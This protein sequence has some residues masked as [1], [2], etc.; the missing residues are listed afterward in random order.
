MDRNFDS[1]ISR[2]H[3]LTMAGATMLGVGASSVWAQEPAQQGPKFV[4]PEMPALSAEELERLNKQIAAQAPKDGTPEPPAPT[5]TASE[6]AGANLGSKL[7]ATGRIKGL[8]E[9]W[10][11]TNDGGIDKNT[12]CGQ[13][14]AATV[15][16]YWRKCP[17]NM[18]NRSDNEPVR[19]LERDSRWKQ[20]IDI[21]VANYG[22]T[23]WRMKSILTGHGM[24]VYE[25]SGE[26][27]I[28]EWLRYGYPLIVLTDVG[29]IPWRDAKGKEIWGGHWVVVYAYETDTRGNAT[30]YF[31]SNWPGTGKVSRASFKSCWEH[32]I[33]WWAGLGGKA[34]LATT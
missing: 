25:I 23:P 1:P 18:V 13:A 14:A 3:F 17:S 24:K 32:G 20:D 21:K 8:S 15:L 33:P 22:T 2:K 11:Y 10:A 12:C 29:K 31:L 16:N 34:I 4:M 5:K 7:R 19:R 28:Q 6:S 9:I 27:K 26:A 30:S